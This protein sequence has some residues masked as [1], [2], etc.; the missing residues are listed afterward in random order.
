MKWVLDIMLQMLIIASIVSLLMGAT[1]FFLAGGD[2]KQI[3][4]IPL[5]IQ[6]GK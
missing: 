5:T 2:T 6:Q 4:N 1:F 3:K